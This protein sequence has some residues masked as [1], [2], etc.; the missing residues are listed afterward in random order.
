[1]S[2]SFTRMNKLKN[3]GEII[4]YQRF[5]S[6]TVAAVAESFVGGY[7]KRAYC[8]LFLRDING[9]LYARHAHWLLIYYAL[10]G[11]RGLKIIAMCHV[12]EFI[13]RIV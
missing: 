5:N 11:S 1:M 12:C 8:A 4:G 13:H 7:R 9:K 3:G 10:C 6:I 2:Q